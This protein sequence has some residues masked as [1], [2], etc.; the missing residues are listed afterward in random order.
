[1]GVRSPAPPASTEQAV[2]ASA[3][4]SA[5][6]SPLASLLDGLGRLAVRYPTAV[7]VPAAEE[8]PPFLRQQGAQAE[9]A[10]TGDPA[11]GTLVASAS[12][13]AETVTIAGVLT[14]SDVTGRA[15]TRLE[16]G[17]LTADAATTYGG[18]T[19]AGVPVALTTD[20]LVVAEDTPLLPGPG[21]GHARGPAQRRPRGRRCRDRAH[22]PDRADQ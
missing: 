5:P 7:Q 22:L 3:P 11:A 1:M 12:S 10:A 14:I 18:I 20:G 9:A 17:E 13:T 6:A 19:V 8:E 2:G 4:I 21:G 16:D 15:V